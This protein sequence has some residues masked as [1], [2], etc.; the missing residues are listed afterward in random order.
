MV[1][2]AAGTYKTPNVFAGNGGSFGN[3]TCASRVRFVG[4]YSLATRTWNSK[5]VTAD[6]QV[7][8]STAACVDVEGLDLSSTN[9]S[10]T[11]A[12]IKLSGRGDRLISSHVHDV[13]NG[14]CVLGGGNADYLE[15]RGNW[16][17]RCGTPDHSNNMDHGIYVSQSN[18]T[19]VDNIVYDSSAYC[20]SFYATT[21][22]IPSYGTIS[23]NTMWY[24]NYGIGINSDG[25]GADYNVITNN[26]LL[27]LKYGISI[28][29]YGLHNVVANNLVWSIS[30]PRYDGGFSYTGDINANPLFVNWA[31]DGSG[32]YR[33]SAD[34]PALSTGTTTGAPSVDW[35]NNPSQAGSEINVGAFHGAN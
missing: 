28:H 35:L 4:D 31:P 10:S 2:I 11:G 29:N 17:H 13:A 9:M 32:D 33:L 8:E 1:H 20:I 34:S 18:I 21:P 15:I 6:P 25:G 3:G 22:G 27:Y 26:I 23:N 5:V 24:C 16:V 14:T 30:G 7:W 12:G 19:A